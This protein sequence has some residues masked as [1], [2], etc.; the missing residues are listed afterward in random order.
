MNLSKFLAGVLLLLMLIL[1]VNPA[2]ATPLDVRIDDHDFTF[3]VPCWF[4]DQKYAVYDF[5]GSAPDRLYVNSDINHYVGSYA[6]TGMLPT[7][8]SSQ[9][10]APPAASPWLYPVLFA[11]QFGGAMSLDM[12]FDKN[13]GPYVNIGA[14]APDTYDI[15]LT[16]DKGVLRITGGIGTQGVPINYLYPA[17]GSIPQDV[18]LL[19]ILFDKTSLLAKSAEDRI[20]LVEGQ[21]K[22]TKLLGRDLEEEGIILPVGVTFYKFIA[23]QP[24][25]V[26]FP[27]TAAAPYDPLVEYNL[28][29][30]AGRVSGEAG[31]I[32][33]PVTLSML[34]LGAITM[35]GL[36]RFH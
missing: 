15:S 7:V 28:A 17:M 2:F 11:Q 34:I 25:T 30:I 33:E 3:D 6:Y 20:F 5:Q 19:E 27:P 36:R 35:V 21:G 4:P 16:G 13:D 31:V 23:G 29:S 12:V 9:L 32:P 26:I 14:G 8:P 18:V 24:G 22:V 10:G 1:I